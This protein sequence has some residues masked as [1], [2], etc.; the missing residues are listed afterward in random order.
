M[1]EWGVMTE[2][3]AKGHGR[4]EDWGQLRPPPAV[5]GSPWS[6]CCQQQSE[7]G[8]GPPCLLLRSFP[9]YSATGLSRDLSFL[10]GRHCPCLALC[11]LVQPQSWLSCP[12][13]LAPFALDMC[14]SCLLFHL[15]LTQSGSSLE[16]EWVY[17]T[18]PNT[19]VVHGKSLLA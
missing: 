7:Q 12:F 3:K 19:E 17:S 15:P 2:R 4:I 16:P 14:R 1:P 9:K 18:G 5:V 8:Q 13:L 10:S 6:W 11:P